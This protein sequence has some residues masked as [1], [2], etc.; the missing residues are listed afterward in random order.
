[1][2]YFALGVPIIA[3]PVGIE[4]RLTQ[5]GKIPATHQVAGNCRECVIRILPPRTV[6]IREKESPRS[7]FVD[8]R[9]RQRSA[10]CRSEFLL[11][12]GGFGNHI[13][14]QRVRS[15]IQRRVSDRVKEVAMR[16]VRIESAAARHDH[17]GP[18]T[19]PSGVS[20]ALGH[21]CCWT[22]SSGLYLLDKTRQS[23]WRS[24]LCV[25]TS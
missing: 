14:R 25:V 1:M 11:P 23:T 15:R 18:A 17:S 22:S 19:K 9:D 2:N 12:I 7:A 13:S 20:P 5:P 8:F 4:T 6:V 10:K 3:D 24:L 16:S 21:Q